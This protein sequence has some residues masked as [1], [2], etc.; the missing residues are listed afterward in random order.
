MLE[1]LPS[2]ACSPGSLTASA[3]LPGMPGNGWHGSSQA[4]CAEQPSWG[5]EGLCWEASPEP[6]DPLLDDTFAQGASSDS[7]ADWLG[8]AHG[9]PLLPEPSALQQVAHIPNRKRGRPRRYDT[10][11]PLGEWGWAGCM[12]P[13]DVTGAKEN[14]ASLSS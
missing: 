12:H 10:T 5:S 13:A 1:A 11:L 2:G 14:S 4:A 3:E 8:S 6:A 7:S 9:L